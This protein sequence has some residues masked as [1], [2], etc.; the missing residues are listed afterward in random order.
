MSVKR[1]LRTNVSSIVSGMGVNFG[2]VNEV[3]DPVHDQELNHVSFYVESLEQSVD[4][5][6]SPG[7]PQYL[8]GD[9]GR[10]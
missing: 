5:S 10:L 2:D 3:L 1:S 9:E 6:T 8:G 7:G 4:G